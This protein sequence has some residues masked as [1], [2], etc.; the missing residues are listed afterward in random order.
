MFL[1]LGLLCVVVIAL[2]AVSSVTEAEKNGGDRS[3]QNNPENG[4]QDQRGQGARPGVKNDDNRESN[5]N[6]RGRSG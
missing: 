5:P 3:N 1:K 4:R 2:L 6:S